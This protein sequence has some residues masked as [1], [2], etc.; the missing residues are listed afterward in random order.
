MG[1]L[2]Y[3][4]S[5]PYGYG[6][7]TSGQA[8]S[9]GNPYGGEANPNQGTSYG[10]AR[11]RMLY[12]IKADPPTVERR[13]STDVPAMPRMVVEA[14]ASPRVEV[15]ELQVPASPRVEVGQLQAP[16]SPRMEVAPPLI[17]EGQTSPVKNEPTGLPG[18]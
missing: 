16:L 3:P 5:S 8:Y 9:P 11:P 6:S 1:Q 7:Y 13:P 10:S 17:P 12:R 15:G 4:N 14:P 18:F 2:T